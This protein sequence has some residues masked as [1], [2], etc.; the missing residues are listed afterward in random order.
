[1]AQSPHPP[2]QLPSSSS[3]KQIRTLKKEYGYYIDIT[4]AIDQELT[5][6]L[7]P[8]KFIFNNNGPPEYHQIPIG[9][10]IRIITELVEIPRVASTGS[11]SII[12]RSI[13]WAQMGKNV[14]K[15]LT[16]LGKGNNMNEVMI[17]AIGM[18]CTDN[19]TMEDKLNVVR[20]LHNESVRYNVLY[21]IENAIMYAIQRNNFDIVK[22]LYSNV[23]PQF[24]IH[25]AIHLA[26]YRG[27]KDIVEF[28]HNTNRP[29]N[30]NGTIMS[31]ATGGILMLL[32]FYTTSTTFMT[33]QMVMNS[34]T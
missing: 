16:V 29:Y 18:N 2:Q 22:F 3:T 21:N 23:T 5:R 14:E 10:I 7:T 30:V 27:Y 17:K 11:L 34:P 20:F 12:Q 33:N 8:I 6:L 31:A 32:N 19:Y 4:Y 24:Q 1:M 26:A 25:D 13:L 15:L 28:L 9:K